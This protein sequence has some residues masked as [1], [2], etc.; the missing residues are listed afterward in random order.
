MRCIQPGLL[1]G[2]IKGGAC[3]AVGVPLWS[4]TS[5]V[6]CTVEFE[7]HVHTYSMLSTNKML[8]AMQWSCIA[9][10]VCPGYT[11]FTS[12][13]AVCQARH[14]YTTMNGLYS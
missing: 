11:M 4:R 3:V 8:Q 1:L 2:T 14:T 13:I 12:S 9:T 7:G 5:A 10:G 6:R